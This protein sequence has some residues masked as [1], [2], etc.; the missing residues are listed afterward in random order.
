MATETRAPTTEY[1]GRLFELYTKYVSE[2]ESKKDVY[3]YSLL[4]VGY[5]L[6]LIGMLIYFVGP[7][8][9]G[10]SQDT[11]FLVRKLAAIPAGIGLV[12][13][14][15][16]IVLM[17]PV[18]RRSLAVTVLGAI[19]AVAA[20]GLFTMYY[21]N[22]W[23]Q[24][25]PS[26][27][28]LIITLYSVGVALVAGVVIMVPVVT[29]KRSYFSETTE[30]HRYEH[31]EIMIGES[32]R[33]GLFALFKQ[34]GEW[35]WRL[36]HE[37]GNI[38]A[39]SGEGY[40]GRTRCREGAESVARNVGPDGDAEFEVYEDNRGDHRWRLKAANNE[41]VATSGEGY[42]SKSSAEEAVERIKRLAPDA[43]ALDVGL[44]AF[45]VY[46][47]QSEEWR[48]RLR[49]R[50][51]NVIADSGEGYTERNKAH[52]AIESVKRNAPGAET[53]R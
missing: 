40:S 19:A 15:F 17:L 11:I 12:A 51:G 30:G 6:A 10:V 1:D 27:S 26:Y 50:N 18:T 47:D 13:T 49:H 36:L 8:S 46:E 53:E 2:P 48:W 33:G 35:R 14:L 25:S 41:I 23:Q 45:E 34:A 28:G 9:A 16:G 5:L 4:V 42:S 20:I 24:G 7:T 31:P 52:D 43:D 29:G 32:D 38:L 37:N 22:N 3:G 21:P 39:D 44:A